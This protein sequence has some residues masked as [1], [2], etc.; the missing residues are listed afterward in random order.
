MKTT[1]FLLLLSI[2]AYS[3]AGCDGGSTTITEGNIGSIDVKGIC[4]GML[5]S[6]CSMNWD[7]DLDGVYS[8]LYIGQMTIPHTVIQ[9]Y[10]GA[11]METFSKDALVNWIYSNN[12]SAQYYGGPSGVS[13]AEYA[14][15][16]ETWHLRITVTLQN[17]WNSFGEDYIQNHYI[18][19]PYD[20]S[21]EEVYCSGVEYSF[22]D[23]VW[24]IPS[25]HTNEN[26]S[27]SNGDAWA[28]SY[29]TL[30]QTANSQYSMEYTALIEGYSS[31]RPLSVMV[32]ELKEAY[33]TSTVE[34]GG[35]VTTQSPS[36][37]MTDYHFINGGVAE[38]MGAGLIQNGLDWYFDPSVSGSGSHAMFVRTNNNGCMSEWRDTVFYVTPIVTSF[39]AP[40]WNVSSTFAGENGLLAG[41]N[42]SGNPSFAGWF[43]MGCSDN[44]Y[45]FA[46][47]NIQA[48]L[49]LE[50]QVIFHNSIIETGS[51]T[52]SFTVDM[53][54]RNEIYLNQDQSIFGIDSIEANNNLPYN[55]AA[56]YAAGDITG[57]GNVTAD[58]GLY[59]D[60]MGD[61]IQISG[62]FVNTFGDASDYQSFYIGLVPTPY[63]DK[64][65]PLCYSGD[66]IM[67][68]VTD[69]PV[70][71]DTMD[72]NAYRS[73]LWDVDMDF[74]IELD[75]T[76]DDY[77][78][79]MPT[80]DKSN[81]M[82]Q[83]IV[84]STLIRGYSPYHD[85][86]FDLWV[87]GT[88]ARCVSNYDTTF[89]VRYPEF[90]TNFSDVDTI[91]IGT[92][93]QGV[94]TGVWFDAQNDTIEWNWNDNSPTYYGDSVWHYYNDLGFYTLNIAVRDSF[95]CQSD[96]TYTD[97]WFVPGVLDLDEEVEVEL[98]LYPVPVRHKLTIETSAKV[99]EV[100]IYNILGELVERTNESVILTDRLPNGTY[101]V[102][103]QTNKGMIERKIIKL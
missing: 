39:N 30:T 25:D 19:N 37:L 46:T 6:N 100:T 82:R 56:A 41:K 72:Y 36:T 97:H 20:I 74:M 49:T 58:D 48:G 38:Y 3:Y 26:I 31:R 35:P 79:I 98:T 103:I 1:L 11:G 23:I 13:I 18:K 76:I 71:M 95:G 2:G 32:E 90:T 62:R 78:L 59:T 7:D 51:T 102:R 80:I 68:P 77:Q 9:T 29:V 28:G 33:F 40:I 15:G 91:S 50:Y 24:N 5:E 60:Y 65:Q 17:F 87:E 55:L 89:V 14:G 44:T 4:S 63:V 86:Y 45:T 67:S 81:M 22:G 27:F 92:P 93:V 64:T 42:V 88:S 73:V 99:E 84:D 75:G 57:D 21:Y 96:T 16:V 12:N 53:P 101:I 70:Y 94:V 66:P 54:T 34:S 10:F 8:F 85:Q 47:S 83:V 52:G 43:H 69:V 61:P